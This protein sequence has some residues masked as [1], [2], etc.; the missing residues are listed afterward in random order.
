MLDDFEKDKTKFQN[1]VLF[2][3]RI[4]CAAIFLFAGFAKW[5]FWSAPPEDMATGLVN[6]IRFL[7]IVEPLGAAALLLGFLTRW[8]AAGLAIIMVGAVFV[9]R[10]TMQTSFF[11][12][13]QGLGFDYNLLIFGNCIALIA[14]GAGDWSIDEMRRKFDIL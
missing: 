8:A 11:T 6:L 4:V 7:S 1:A 9:L 12:T 3:L 5:S 14:F 13:P 2:L 10:F